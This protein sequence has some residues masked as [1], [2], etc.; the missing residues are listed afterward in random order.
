[1]NKGIAEKAKEVTTLDLRKEFK[2]IY[3][4]PAKGVVV[5]DVP[6]MQF[7]MIDG[8]GNPNTAQQ[9]Q[10]AVNAL[11]SLAFTLKFLV[12]KELAVD[13]PMMPLEGL[14]WTVDM[15]TFSLEN[16]DDWQWTMMLMQP[17]IITPALLSK[18]LAQAVQKKHLP[19]LAHIRL[20]RFEEGRCAQILHL[21]PYAT[22]KPTVEKLHLF[23][24]EHGY[25]LRGK[26]HEIY[27]GDP[28]KSAPD[29]LRTLIRQPIA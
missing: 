25:N 5:V 26:H 7:L 9:Y 15:R 8:A 23:I 1:M 10:D 2:R 20:A 3:Q 27:L 11:Y 6:I 28:R 19:A 12:K 14:W 21:G 17:D 13:Y 4:P 22:E 24:Q 18:A 29:K 16:K